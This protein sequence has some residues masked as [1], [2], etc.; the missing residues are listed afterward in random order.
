MKRAAYSFL[1]SV[2]LSTGVLA[3]GKDTI[4]PLSSNISRAIAD[5]YRPFHV[6]L[7]FLRKARR[8]IAS[9]DVI[10]VPWVTGKYRKLSCRYD[11]RFSAF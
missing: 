8:V 10:L 3:E 4:E 2:L 1:V 11:S 5:V 9:A 6:E 7:H